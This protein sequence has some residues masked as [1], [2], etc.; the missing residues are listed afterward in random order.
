MS[1]ERFSI[2]ILEQDVLEYHKNKTKYNEYYEL[3]KNALFGE[4]KEKLKTKRDYWYNKY[5]SKMS[6][7]EKNYRKTNVYTNYHRKLENRQRRYT[8][9]NNPV[10]RSIPPIASAPPLPEN[11]FTPIVIPIAIPLSSRNPHSACSPITIPPEDCRP[12]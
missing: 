8:L 2:M 4:E 9:E 11:S 1:N 7:L 6:Y 10:Q 12:I 3:H 5:I